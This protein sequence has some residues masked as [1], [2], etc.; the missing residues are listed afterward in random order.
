MAPLAVDVGV[1]PAKSYKQALMKD[2]KTQEK[3]LEELRATIEQ[4]QAP[5][6]AFHGQPTGQQPQ[7]VVPVDNLEGN[8]GEETLGN[9]VTLAVDVGVM[10]D[11]GSTST[12]AGWWSSDNLSGYTSVANGPVGAG[13]GINGQPLPDTESD[14][15]A[16]E[17]KKWN[18][19]QKYK[20]SDSGSEAPWKSVYGPD[21]VKTRLKQTCATTECDR[22]VGMHCLECKKD[23]CE[24]CRSPMSKDRCV[25]CLPVMLGIKGR[26]WGSGRE[27]AGEVQ[28][29]R[30]KRSRDPVEN[31]V[32]VTRT[33]RAPTIADCKV[34]KKAGKRGDDAKACSSCDALV[35]Y[36]CLGKNQR[37]CKV[38]IESRTCGQCD[39]PL[40]SA[41]SKKCSGKCGKRCHEACI[42][43]HGTCRTC[44]FESGAAAREVALVKAKEVIKSATDEPV[45]LENGTAFLNLPRNQLMALSVVES[46]LS[47]VGK[48]E[49]PYPV[50]FVSMSR[51]KALVSAWST[52]GYA[53]DTIKFTLAHCHGTEGSV[54]DHFVSLVFTTGNV[55]A[56]D[57]LRPKC[58][59][60]LEPTLEAMGVPR[61]KRSISGNGAPLTSGLSCAETC[62]DNF[63][64][65]C[66]LGKLVEEPLLESGA[67][68]SQE[69][70]VTAVEQ[71]HADGPPAP[72]SLVIPR[73]E[74]MDER[75]TTV[76]M[77]VDEEM[78]IETCVLCHQLHEDIQG[79]PG[80]SRRVC[81]ACHNAESCDSCRQV[82]V[83][84]DHAAVG[85]KVR[86]DDRSEASAQP[87]RSRPRK[88]NPVAPP[89]PKVS[90][91]GEGFP[92]VP[93]GGSKAAT[94]AVLTEEGDAAPT[95]AVVPP[96]PPPPPRVRVNTKKVAPAPPVHRKSKVPVT[97]APEGSTTNLPRN[98]AAKAN[99]NADAKKPAWGDAKERPKRYQRARGDI[100][101]ALK[102]HEAK[103]LEEKG[104][105]M[106][107][108]CLRRTPITLEAAQKKTS[109]KI[110]QELLML[111]LFVIPKAKS[112]AEALRKDSRRNHLYT[113]KDV[114]DALVRSEK[115]YQD[116]AEAMADGLNILARERK[117]VPTSVLTK[118]QSLYGV[119]E[120]LDQYTNLKDEHEKRL[121]VKLREC[122][123]IWDD[124]S[125]HWVLGVC[126]Y[127]PSVDEVTVEGMTAILKPENTTLSTAALLILSWCT[128]GRPETWA[129]VLKDDLAMTF[130]KGGPGEA[131]GYRVQV[132]FRH[133]KMAAKLGA[134]VVP[135]L[136]PVEWAQKVFAWKEQTKECKYLFPITE[137]RRIKE[138]LLLAL[139]TQ[140]PKWEL[141]SLRRG[142]L[143]TMARAGVPYDTL[144]L[145]S[146]H[147][148][149]T[150]VT[151][152]LRGGLHAGERNQKAFEAAKHLHPPT[153]EKSTQ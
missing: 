109:S 132:K 128:T 96:P 20:K 40:S 5:V 139:R 48:L 13:G 88:E 26:V 130:A 28:I 141:R 151:R 98:V 148:N 44:A 57:S 62:V 14:N 22:K 73:R 100:I 116:L 118:A 91:H 146:L 107:T 106:G 65:L 68:T 83:A 38:C 49:W 138:N 32:P 19:I 99:A 140:D 18:A 95:P 129:K 70:F 102:D 135:T 80:C 33:A 104:F 63:L 149:D 8:V 9:F 21:R 153:K 87:R 105:L 134:L 69:A 147:T 103:T 75:D 152:Y 60:G 92:A 114:L 108:E 52:P 42:T 2:I 10:T 76:A 93:P 144:K 34:C 150:M 43:S 77:A 31:R 47:H 111:P 85:N 25:H 53:L 119:L 133:H 131:D 112:I 29:S 121:T 143:S 94:P 84:R 78:P 137:W 86:R 71:I 6:V 97:G 54:E 82:G 122:G 15:Q 50:D 67:F 16:R 56:A 120:R 30:Q 79:C 3:T 59:P 51:V 124:V 125:K 115:N 1:I 35:H 89:V 126:G 11:D 123:S 39:R 36:D 145:F 41:K 136:L 117:W 66:L 17:F 46:L 45:E 24:S 55:E 110:L 4:L 64:Q 90:A 113:L 27:S 7:G 72:V 12:P 81:P 101:V 37:E 61:G 23:F 74:R 142:S 58:H 127:E